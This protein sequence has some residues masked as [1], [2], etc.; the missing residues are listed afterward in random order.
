[1]LGILFAL[2]LCPISAALFFG[3]VIPL[4]LKFKS[5]IYLSV[6]YGAGTAIPVIISAFILAYGSHIAG[7][8][9][10]RLNVI[11]I[12]LRKIT[13][14]IFILIGIYFCLKYL[15]GWINF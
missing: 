5:N 4:V 3:S 11:E 13:G 7:K 10:N 9:F 2:S 14:G 6:F 1:M 12:W 15:F 8:F